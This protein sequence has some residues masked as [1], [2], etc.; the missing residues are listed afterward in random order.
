MIRK[1]YFISDFNFAF[2]GLLQKFDPKKAL[3]ATI[4]ELNQLVVDSPK[5]WAK[6][7][8]VWAVGTLAGI[9]SMLG[10][11]YPPGNLAEVTQFWLNQ[12]VTA[13]LSHIIVSGILYDLDNGDF[14]IMDVLM[15]EALLHQECLI[16]FFF[17]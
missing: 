13:K 9:G 15:K 10:P 4:T 17:R 14:G 12:E 11:L 5:Y 2:S 3:K 7:L 8:A 1:G 6:E 16:Q